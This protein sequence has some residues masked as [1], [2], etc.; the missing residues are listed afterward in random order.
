MTNYTSTLIWVN[1][2]PT[3][4]E[5]LVLLHLGNYNR[6]MSW[7]VLVWVHSSQELISHTC[8]LTLFMWNIF[9]ASIH[10]DF[11]SFSNIFSPW[12]PK[13]PS[14]HIY[15]HERVLPSLSNI[16]LVSNFLHIKKR[17]HTDCTYFYSCY[18]RWYTNK[19]G[20][21]MEIERKEEDSLWKEMAAQMFESRN[22]ERSL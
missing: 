13:W 15:F 5:M 18:F 8:K 10:Q 22:T 2:I 20:T 3:H 1:V 9:C 16:Y 14:R 11:S 19:A 17:V 7:H 12:A 6:K 21:T 4:I